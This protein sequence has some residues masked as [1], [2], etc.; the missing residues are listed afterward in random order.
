MIMIPVII[1]TINIVTNQ[2]KNNLD[3][4]TLFI[5][6]FIS[7]NIDLFLQNVNIVYIIQTSFNK[8]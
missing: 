6:I 1:N 4:E 7:D 2:A 8:Y 5:S 3:F